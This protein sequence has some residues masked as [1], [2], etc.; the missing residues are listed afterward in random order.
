M[1]APIV[2]IHGLFGHLQDSRILD[3]FGGREVHAPDL[4]GYGSL[5][6]EDTSSLTLDDQANR[7]ARYV[8]EHDLERVNLVGHS[9]G[10]AV[11][12]LVASSFPEIVATLTSVEG[13]FTLEDAFS[14][15]HLAMKPDEEVEEIIGEYRNDPDAW[16]A[17]AGV[18][19]NEWTQGLA[20]SW[21][22]NQPPSTIK[23]QAKAVVSATT[24][25]TYLGTVKAL[26]ASDVAFNLIAGE[27]SAASWHVPSWVRDQSTEQITIAETGHLMMAE[28]PKAFAAAVIRCAS[29]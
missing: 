9:V 8:G 17:G 26:L 29:R 21:L 5:R 1:A 2:L 11:A 23:A 16:F 7:I 3:G 12:I 25:D 14:S 19:I 18:P 27:R 4:V 15:A 24:P 20:V 6:E 28:D 13:N 10:G 22:N